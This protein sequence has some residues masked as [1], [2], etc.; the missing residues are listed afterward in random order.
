MVACDGVGGLD[1][2]EVASAAVVDGFVGWFENEFPD[3]LADNRLGDRVSLRGLQYVWEDMIACLNEKIFSYGRQRDMGVATTLTALLLMGDHYVMAHVG[4]CRAYR[5]GRGVVKQLS[6]DQTLLA[7]ELARGT[8]TPEQARNYPK[9]NVIL[10]A[11][12]A[13]STVQPDFSVGD[14]DAS[15]VL[16]LCTDGFYKTMSDRDF[17]T[18][19]PLLNTGARGR[20]MPIARLRRAVGEQPDPVQRWCEN[21]GNRVVRNGETD[22]VSVLVGGLTYPPEDAAARSRTTLSTKRSATRP[23][24]VDVTGETGSF[25]PIKQ[26]EDL[27][28]QIARD[29]FRITERV[30][31]H[32]VAQVESGQVPPSTQPDLGDTADYKMP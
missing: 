10:Q 27:E 32:R 17:E 24:G 5:Y 9:K 23:M 7:Y 15:D 13:S 2:G 3:Y 16:L 19:L 12:G 8:I 6:R 25:A 14:W 28:R 20:L 18:L 11:V 30:V 26:L 1:A 21:M 29:H 4:D 22:D 31:E